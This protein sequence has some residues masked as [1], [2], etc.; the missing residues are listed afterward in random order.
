M[1]L[2]LIDVSDDYYKDELFFSDPEELKQIFIKLED[3]N[4]SKIHEQQEMAHA[5]EALVTKEA[6]VRERL[7]HNFDE[8][9]KTRDEYVVKIKTA[10]GILNLLKRKTASAM[11]YDQ[12]GAEVA[13]KGKGPAPV[14]FTKLL[15]TLRER[16][17]VIH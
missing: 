3:D 1:K 16:I 5:F 4:L 12:S 9:S 15:G 17:K 2:S 6:K 14:D 8:Q 13:V 11:V 7:Q 10:Q